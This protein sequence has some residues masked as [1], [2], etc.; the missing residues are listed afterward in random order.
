MKIVRLKWLLLA[1]VLLCLQA[2]QPVEPWERG[3]LAKPQMALEP[4]PMHSAL[5]AHTFASRE[6]GSGESSAV[7]GGCG[8]N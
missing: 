7:G 8:C 1:P 3:D 5:R 6:A 4:N 2:C